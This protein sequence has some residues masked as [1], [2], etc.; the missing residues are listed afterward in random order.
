VPGADWRA[1]LAEIAAQRGLD[2]AATERMAALVELVAADPHAPTAVRDPAEA[3]DVHIADSLTGLE[4]PRLGTAATIADLGS[5]AGFPGLPLAIARR[6]AHVT[7][8]ESATKK[9]DFLRGAVE[10]AGAGNAEVVHARA[11]EWEA[12]QGRCDVVVARAL[13][14]LAVLAEYAAP[15]LV[16]GGALVA[17][18]GRRDPDEESQGAAAAAQLGL[19]SVEIV[20]V[21]PYSG[22]RDRHLVV[23]IK[24]SPTPCRF[25]R[26]PGRARK[27]PLR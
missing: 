9:A 22:S 27:R 21:Q 19:G 18:K 5:G 17:W 2:A 15:L 20:P 8:V 7:L 14:S 6:D 3:V 13:D 23:M 16:L 4:V 11:E 25:P 1:R 24:D 10:A 12:G 26:A